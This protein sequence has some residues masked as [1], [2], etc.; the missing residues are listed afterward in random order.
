MEGSSLC[1]SLSH[2]FACELLPTPAK[3]SPSTQRWET[4]CQRQSVSWP[5]STDRGQRQ[6]EMDT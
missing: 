6:S 1:R 4:K 3:G 2:C 5:R